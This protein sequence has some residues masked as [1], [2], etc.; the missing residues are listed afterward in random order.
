[1]IKKYNLMKLFPLL[2]SLGLLIGII[3]NVVYPLNIKLSCLVIMAAVLL[4]Y[5]WPFF[6]LKTNRLSYPQVRWIILVGLMIIFIIQLLVLRYLPA[7][8]YH[9]PFRVLYQAELLSRGQ[10]TWNAS[11]Y[12]WRY[13]NN[14]PLAFL[15]S[16]WF[17]LTML[18]HLTTNTALHILSLVLLD[19]F[20]AA[21]LFS[22]RRLSHQNSSSLAVLIFFMLSPFAYTYYLQVFYSDLPT[23]I[24]LLVCFNI[25]IDWPSR[26]KQSKGLAGVLLF[27]V[28]LIGQLLKPNLIVLA[29]AIII[30]LMAL[31]LRDRPTLI[32]Y[33]LP[34][35]IILFA[36]G[37]AVPTKSPIDHTVGFTTNAKYELP[38]SHWIWMGYNP[39]GHGT[40]VGADVVKMNQLPNKTVR[41]TYTRQAIP[42]RIKALGISGLLTRWITKAGILT[43]VS[44]LQK[45][46]TGGYIQA[47]ASYQKYQVQLS[48]L[49]SLI[50]R[51]GFIF[52][53]SLALMKCW[54]LL[55]KKGLALNPIRDLAIVIAVGYLAF[56]T[57][58]WEAESRY[59]QP[60]LPLLL[61]IAALPSGEKQPNINVYKQK[62]RNI[63]GA[64]ALLISLLGLVITTK[65][66]ITNKTTIV[67]GQRSQLS[68]QYDAR[69]TT[70]KPKTTVT[71]KIALNHAATKLSVS[72]P[73]QTHLKAQL[74]SADYHKAYHFQ[75]KKAS[76]II[77]HKLAPGKYNIVLQNQSPV[78]QKIE[79]VKT[80]AFKLAPYPTTINGHP[81]KYSSL[82][83]KS[84]NHIS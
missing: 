49:G 36:F 6:K 59:G 29:I 34:F 63:F 47:S 76:L 66:L 43:N 32:K 44:H 82:I 39:S 57:L 84:S 4:W 70:I 72:I 20:I 79:L 46:Y 12:F 45:S 50:M 26:S 56:H 38:A 13:P 54:L 7:T 64:G 62:W 77:K 75:Q 73:A 40:Y 5:G 1:M 37:A 48:L 67:A 18:L 69:L 27:G 55:T 42:Q 81:Y 22:I 24:C 65:P 51:I 83:Y 10:H 17:K 68:L 3:S 52:I 19:G 14:V 25:L 80:Q 60:L 15:L 23:L 58:V 78:S 16:Q 11:T 31:L 61:F 41:Q 9:D 33:L 28:I 53:Y 8:I 35:T 74:V 2:L 21:S 30:L 71:Q